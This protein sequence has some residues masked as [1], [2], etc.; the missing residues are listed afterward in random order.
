MIGLKTQFFLIDVTTDE[1]CQSDSSSSSTDSSSRRKQDSD[2]IVRGILS[3]SMKYNHEKQSGDSSLTLD[4]LL[5]G[6]GNNIPNG[7]TRPLTTTA[8]TS[9][10]P[11]NQ[12]KTSTPLDPETLHQQHID[13][14]KKYKAGLSQRIP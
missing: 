8:T 1:K 9:Q 11:I 13:F 7:N 2:S 12:S 4:R 10:V 14:L 5:N 6:N 3:N